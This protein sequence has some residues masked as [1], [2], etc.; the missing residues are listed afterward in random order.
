MDR[1]PLYLLKGRPVLMMRRGVFPNRAEIKDIQLLYPGSVVRTEHIS[2]P[3]RFVVT[4]A[5]R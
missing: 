4:V 3:P 5:K 1:Q 2:N